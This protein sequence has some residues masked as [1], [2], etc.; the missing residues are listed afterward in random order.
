VIRVSRPFCETNLTAPDEKAGRTGRCPKCKSPFTLPGGVNN[1]PEVLPAEVEV[2]RG[3]WVSQS[4]LHQAE[5]SFFME[6]ERL[7]AA[8]TG[9]VWENGARKNQSWAIKDYLFLTN[10]RV[11]LWGRGLV[12]GVSDALNFEDIQDVELRIEL[13]CAGVFFTCFGRKIGLWRV[14][15]EEAREM[16]ARIR[17]R[18]SRAKKVEVIGS[19][20]SA[21]PATQLE[22]LAALYKQGLLSRDEFEAKKSKLLKLL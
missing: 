2:Y 18:I 9:L 14:R 16:A 1:V 5:D 6:G 19:S 11:I 22:K 17:S 7:E 15:A 4:H 20:S 10:K 13:L 3:R 21:D 12:S 8:I